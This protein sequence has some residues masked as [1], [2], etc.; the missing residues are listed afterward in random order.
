MIDDDNIGPIKLPREL[1]T[2]TPAAPDGLQFAYQLAP[3]G[4]EL[5]ALLITDPRLGAVRLLLTV[6]GARVV[7]ATLAAMLDQ[8]PELRDEWRISGLN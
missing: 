4:T 5:I 7:A 2:I 6:D 1:L 8:L 3:D